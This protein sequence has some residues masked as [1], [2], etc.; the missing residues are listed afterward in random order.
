[1]NASQAALRTMVVGS[2]YAGRRFLR[3]LDYDRCT[4][5][6][7]VVAL[8]DRDRGALAGA[9]P[10]PRYQDLGLALHRE[11]PEVVV[12]CVNEESHFAVLDT[13]LAAPSVRHVICEKPLTRTMEEFTLLAP[14]RRGVAV[15]VNFCER[16]SPIV[17]ECAAWLAGREASIVRIEFYWGKYRVRDPRPTM[18]VLSELSHPL[19]LARYLLGRADDRPLRLASVFA[20]HSDFS[21]FADRLPDGVS[22]LAELGGAVLAGSSSFVWEERR[23]RLILFAR[24]AG[25]ERAWQIVLDF[26]NP[27][28]DDDTLTIWELDPETGRRAEV[29]R[30]THRAADLPGTIRHVW[31]IHRYL[32]DVADG[33]SGHPGGARYAD[34]PDA[35]W[36]QTALDHI[37]RQLRETDQYSYTRLFTEQ[38]AVAGIGGAPK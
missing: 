1:M 17:D 3:A 12:V 9:G 29:Q 23:R 34:L 14:Q 25:G 7:Q 35:L 15:S 31:K 36:V 4:E 10:V 5:L 22:V 30:F 16:Y 6:Y 18:G 21:G 27:V 2:G 26:D 13:V 32:V 37:D 28:W 38:V 19:D 20:T 11:S 8:V 24:D 33:L